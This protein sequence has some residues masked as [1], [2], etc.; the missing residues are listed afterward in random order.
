MKGTDQG[1]QHSQFKQLVLNKKR[2]R[3]TVFQFRKAQATK[4]QASSTFPK[5][6]RPV[7]IDHPIVGFGYLSCPPST[8]LHN[9]PPFLVQDGE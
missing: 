3:A 4:L 2:E 6:P 9:A 1:G 5:L 8:T 7:L